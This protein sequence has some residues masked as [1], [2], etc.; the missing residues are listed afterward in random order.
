MTLLDHANA[1]VARLAGGTV[2]GELERYLREVVLPYEGNEC[3]FW[4]YSR[5]G[6]GYAQMFRGGKNLIVSRVVCTAVNGDPPGADFDASHLCDNGHLG[7]VTK[8]HLIWETHAENMKRQA[9]R[10]KGR[11]PFEVEVR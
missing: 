6:H 1:Q 3:L 9:G 5:D 2:R 10:P 8:R 11:R 4:P 7:C